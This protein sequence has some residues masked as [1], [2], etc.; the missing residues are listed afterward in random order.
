MLRSQFF[1]EFLLSGFLLAFRERCYLRRI[2]IGR[3]IRS[4]LLLPMP[5]FS[6]AGNKLRHYDTVPLLGSEE[7]PK[8]R[9]KCCQVVGDIE[10][11][12]KKFRRR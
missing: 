9:S 8:M 1:T 4:L 12:L 10:W 3:G 11:N 5:L 2:S 7:Q 6:L